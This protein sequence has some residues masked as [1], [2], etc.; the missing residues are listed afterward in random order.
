DG[1]WAARERLT[2]GPPRLGAAV[3]FQ[4]VH[5]AAVS[6]EHCRHRLRHVL[7]SW[8]RGL[9]TLAAPAPHG[10]GAKANVRPRDVPRA[11]RPPRTAASSCSPRR[12]PPSSGRGSTPVPGGRGC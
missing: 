1:T 6:E 9:R 11:P 2:E 3:L 7:T 10:G 5:R 8:V 4:R 12:C